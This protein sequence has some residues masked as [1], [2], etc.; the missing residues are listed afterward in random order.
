MSTFIESRRAPLYLVFGLFAGVF[1][2][3]QY[4]RMSDFEIAVR[5]S[6][7][8]ATREDIYTAAF[9]ELH[10]YYSP[11]FAVLLSA[12]KALPGT[13]VY[14]L[15]KAISLLCLFRVW[16]LAARALNADDLTMSRY[17]WFVGLSFLLTGAFINANFHNVQMSA[18]ILFCAVEGMARIRAGQTLPGA[19]LVALGIN[20]KILPIVLLPYLLYRGYRRALLWTLLFVG[21]SFALPAVVIG[22]DYNVELHR[23]WWTLLNPAA[24]GYVLDLSETGWTSLTSLVASLFTPNIPG[25]NRPPRNIADLP[26]EQI[27]I[28]I[29]I[30]RAALIGFFLYFLRSLPFRDGQSSKHHLWELSY[31][32]LITPLIFPRQQSY[33]FLLIFPAVIY[34]MHAVLEPGWSD[35]PVRLRTIVVVLLVVCFLLNN[36]ELLWGTWRRYYWHYKIIAYGTLLLI[37]PL[38]ICK[39]RVRELKN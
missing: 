13:A 10:Y 33:A 32:L 17:R 35:R 28:I 34:L 22:W 21:L 6:G 11:L 15:W 5:A 23:S 8:L 9:N 25:S 31:L 12:V 14:V 19:A 18:F 1:L 38:A 7:L 26:I 27:S 30:C 20:I 39:P 4:D 3:A 16:T 2:I 24:S 36:L 37:V 29:N